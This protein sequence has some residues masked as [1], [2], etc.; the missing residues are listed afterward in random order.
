MPSTQQI[1]STEIKYSLI[2]L[3]PSPML[4]HPF[5]CRLGGS[6]LHHVFIQK[7]IPPIILQML[8]PP[9]Q[10]QPLLGHLSGQHAVG[11]G[12]PGGGG[13][14]EYLHHLIHSL[15]E[16]G[17]VPAQLLKDQVHEVARRDR[18]S[19]PRQIMS[20]DLLC[21]VVG[22]DEIPG[23][24]PLIKPI[25]PAGVDVHAH[26]VIEHVAV[27]HPGQVVPEGHQ[28]HRFRRFPQPVHERRQLPVRLHDAASAHAVRRHQGRP[29]PGAS[30][31]SRAHPSSKQNTERIICQLI[32]KE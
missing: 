12:P 8:E 13:D 17:A 24:V 26:L 4:A 22:P 31:R 18:R 10:L 28:H 19:L 6:L 5:L 30:S 14:G 2:C 3:L 7:L 11:H 16:P 25:I 21:R 9:V 15:H 20:D 23:G 27:P 29:T 1:P 32:N